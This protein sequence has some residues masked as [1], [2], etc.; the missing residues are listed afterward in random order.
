MVAE[1]PPST[2][3]QFWTR[4]SRGCQAFA[5]HDE[6]ETTR[7]IAKVGWYN[8]ALAGSGGFAAHRRPASR[9]AGWKTAFIG[10]PWFSWAGQVR[11]E[12]V[13]GNTI[14]SGNVN[15]TLGADFAITVTGSHTR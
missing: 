9:A 11:A 1:G 5:R 2:T 13:G 14:V 3:L 10:N 4:N 12:V 6:V 7:V 15:A 8:S